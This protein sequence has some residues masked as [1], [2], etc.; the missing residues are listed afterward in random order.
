MNTSQPS[1]TD[2]IT[3][4]KSSI[5][6]FKRNMRLFI[7]IAGILLLL[8]IALMCG[9][10][11]LGI[12]GGMIKSYGIETGIFSLLKA[13]LIFL[14]VFLIFI[15][16]VAYAWFSGSLTIAVREIASGR[17]TTIKNTLK[18]GWIIKWSFLLVTILFGLVIV[19]GMILLIIPGI[20]FF[21]WYFLCTYVLVC[22]N[23]KG[24]A[25]LSRSRELVRGYWWGVANR[26]SALCAIL[27]GISFIIAFMPY[28]GNVMNVLFYQF[29]T[30]PFSTIYFLIL[31]KNLEAVKKL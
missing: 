12:L 8:N 26:V 15:W 31:Y 16:L 4:L 17:T 27:I 7:C 24:R 30:L 10:A 18:D 2:T 1:L 19:G 20:V 14:E 9:V 25:A 11:S 6:L 22:E 5:Y 29:I 3:L 23:L 21:T 28:F 13:S